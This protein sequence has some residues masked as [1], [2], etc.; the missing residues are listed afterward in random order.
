MTTK[1]ITIKDVRFNISEIV[2]YARDGKHIEI[3]L[4]R[5]DIR[6]FHYPDEETAIA[7]LASLD[8]AIAKATTD[9]HRPPPTPTDS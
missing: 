3:E 1:F 5:S 4:A 6:S 9:P 2:A 7:V 8:K